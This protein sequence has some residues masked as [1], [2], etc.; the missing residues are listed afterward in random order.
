MKAIYKMHCD[1]GRMGA[2]TGIFTAE[3][4]DMA[5]LIA[6]EK[7]VYFG[8][9]LG[10]HSQIRGPIEEDEITLVSDDPSVVELFESLKMDTGYN[11]FDYITDEDED[12]E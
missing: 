7:E 5:E 6:S 11:P 9:V 12:D 4:S 8:E 10:K 1:C 2:L 3:K